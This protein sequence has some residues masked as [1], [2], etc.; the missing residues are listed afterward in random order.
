M[1]T[2]GKAT[3]F[4]PLARIICPNQRF[5]QVGAAWVSFPL[6]NRGWAQAPT[7]LKLRT[8]PW[9]HGPVALLCPS[10]GSLP[11]PLMPPAVLPCRLLLLLE[12][13]LLSP[14]YAPSGSSL[15]SGSHGP[16]GA[17]LK[18]PMWRKPCGYGQA[19]WFH[20]DATQAGSASHATGRPLELHPPWNCSVLAPQL[21]PKGMS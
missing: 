18:K 13:P 19:S 17:A 2:D 10:P 21:F 12:R 14:D 3:A 15:T 5:Q 9:G 8:E 4:P 1:S 11:W 20:N 6:Q 7:D 16:G